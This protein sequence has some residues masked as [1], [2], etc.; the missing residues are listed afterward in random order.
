MAGNFFGFLISLYEMPFRFVLEKSR[1]VFTNEF[2]VL[3]YFI[4]GQF[5]QKIFDLGSIQ[6]GKWYP[7][8]EK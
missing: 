3:V 4:D 5:V 7:V 8:V 6:K 2:Q 1:I